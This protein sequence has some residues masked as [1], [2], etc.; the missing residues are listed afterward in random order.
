ML[1]SQKLQL[2]Q[3]EVRQQINDFLGQDELAD[4]DRESM[5][6]LTKR[7][8]HIETELRAALTVESMDAETRTHKDDGEARELRSLLE[9]VSIGEYLGIASTGAGLT[10]RAKEL[11][12]ALA[13]PIQGVTGATPIPWA[14]LETRDG[15]PE[16]LEKRAFTTTERIR[17]RRWPAAYP[18][19]SF[20]AGDYG[21]LGESVSTAY[22]WA[23]L[24][25][26]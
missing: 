23:G 1:K 21:R 2:E 14:V 12:E 15:Q 11:N 4:D 3:S 16:D 10:G 9:G 24:N 18:T 5:G 22:Q 13:V 7:A 19:A 26:R 6:R 25:G 8:Q 20:R 17:W